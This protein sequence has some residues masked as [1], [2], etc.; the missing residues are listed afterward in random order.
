LATARWSRAEE[1]LVISAAGHT[2]NVRMALL[3][4]DLGDVIRTGVSGDAQ[5]DLGPGVCRVLGEQCEPPSEGV[6][7][8]VWPIVGAAVVA[9]GI[10]IG[11]V[12]ER[13]RDV[14]FC[15]PSGC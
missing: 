7:W 2:G 8:W 1:L 15:P 11:V 4:T 5:R 12:V 6:P 13:E 10:S 3:D 9:G 14:A